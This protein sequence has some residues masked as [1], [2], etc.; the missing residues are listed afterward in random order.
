MLHCITVTTTPYHRLGTDG[1]V[2]RIVAISFANPEV[3]TKSI[4]WYQAYINMHV[5][6]IRQDFIPRLS[7]V[8]M[9]YVRYTQGR[10]SRLDLKESY[11]LPKHQVLVVKTYSDMSPFFCGVG[12]LPW[13]EFGSDGCGR[14]VL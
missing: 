8:S 9:D 4:T 7:T 1:S 2:L 12:T 5:S 13:Y 3:A 6:E 14:H 10:C 11:R